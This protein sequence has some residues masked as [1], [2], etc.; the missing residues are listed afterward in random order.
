MHTG[1][2]TLP[3]SPHIHPHQ[4][5]LPSTSSPDSPPPSQHTVSDTVPLGPSLC[6]SRNTVSTS[7]GRSSTQGRRRDGE[8]MC[9]HVCMCA[10]ACVCVC[11]CVRA[12]QSV[13]TVP[14]EV[15]SCTHLYATGTVGSVLI[16]EVRLLL[17]RCAFYITRF[18]CTVRCNHNCGTI[19]YKML[20]GPLV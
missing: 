6:N 18:H 17:E 5:T 13:H 4:H 8:I 1:T 16:R 20:Q 10:R 2:L 19:N 9:V 14:P 7:V 11:V 12:R 3:P 15:T